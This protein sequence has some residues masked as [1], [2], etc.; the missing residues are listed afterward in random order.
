MGYNLHVKPNTMEMCFSFISTSS[1][2][3]KLS[4]PFFTMLGLMVIIYVHIYHLVCKHQK[5]PLDWGHRHSGS[6]V[7]HLVYGKDTQ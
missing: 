1:F 4:I 7:R 5:Q 2:R 6:Q 3:M